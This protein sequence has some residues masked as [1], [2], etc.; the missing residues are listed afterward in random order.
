M[1]RTMCNGQDFFHRVYYDK[2]VASGAPP[3]EHTPTDTYIRDGH[4]LRM[5]VTLQVL[6]EIAV[7][8]LICGLVSQNLHWNDG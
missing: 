7:S 8:I 6:K 2:S 4:F 5:L 1:F 3:M